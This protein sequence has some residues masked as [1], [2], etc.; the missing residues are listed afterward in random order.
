MVSRESKIQRL[1]RELHRIRTSP[2]LR[3]GS[4]VTDA[5]RRPWLAPF[6]VLTLPWNML[7]IGLEMLGKKSPPAAFERVTQDPTL[8]E[9]NCVV[10]F[11][12]NGVGFGHFT[13]M[14]ALA[15]HMKNEDPTLEIIFFTTMPTLHLLKPYGIPAHY[16]SGS[17]YFDEMSTIEWN[18]LLE[19]ELAICFEAHRPKQF[20]F[21][22]AFPYRGM[23]R[24]IKAR[25]HLDSIWMRR[26]TFR[27][28]KSIPVDSISH[29]D[30]IIH[31]EDSI[32]MQSSEVEHKVPSITCPPI[33]LIEPSEQM[34]R[35]QA[36]RRLELPQD[37]IVVYVQI[38]AGE[39]NDINSEVRLTVDALTK[40]EN[41]HVVLG[42]S[43][44]GER[45]DID[46][47]R[48]HLLRDYPNSLYYNAFDC[49]IQ[50]GGYNSFHEVRRY[51]L[52]TLFYPNLFTGMD[53]QLARCMAAVDEGWGQVLEDRD[54]KTI[55][56]AI[57]ELLSRSGKSEPLD[58]ESG[59]IT[60]AQQLVKR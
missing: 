15:K 36:R 27:R 50:A 25:P 37:A 12:T 48:V 32:A 30:L 13:R 55:S 45:F 54:E 3:L 31:P 39:I 56:T 22:G 35:S 20:I 59:A 60:L 53:D 29:F 4:I 10:I 46:L 40:R 1:E 5:M 14:L 47:P 43:M 28:G 16:I 34:S 19:E 58:V 38:G 8:S 49:S 21:D 9:R 24:A 41:V 17:P 33:T 44:L 6:L 42:E 51:G 11:P 23:L 26:G 52:P 18:G 57:D 7:M 2:S